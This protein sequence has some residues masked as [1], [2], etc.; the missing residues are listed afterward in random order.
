MSSKKNCSPKPTLR[1]RKL[2]S[3]LE[4]GEV[5]DFFTILS[6]ETR[7]RIIHALA[8][9]GDLCVSELA[10]Q[11]DM[12]PQA[13]SNQLQRLSDRKILESRRDGNLIYYRIVDP[14]VTALLDQ[15]L[16]LAQDARE[17]R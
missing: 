15:G 6:N 17:G 14:C 11:L 5:C 9:E 4:A 3:E 1:E 8:K 7:L 12:K 2:L 10:S 13:I 16:C